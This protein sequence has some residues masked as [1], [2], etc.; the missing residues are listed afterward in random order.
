MANS[1]TVSKPSDF[2]FPH[3]YGRRRLEGRFGGGLLALGSPETAVD[4][5][6]AVVE[7]REEKVFAPRELPLSSLPVC[8][9]QK[10]GG[11]FRS[12]RVQ[13]ASFSAKQTTSPEQKEKIPLVRVEREQKEIEPRLYR[14]HLNLINS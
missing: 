6:A 3:F 2:F 10:R 7:A 12:A 5:G 13:T 14:R 4:Q 11:V 8:R 1:P 9:E